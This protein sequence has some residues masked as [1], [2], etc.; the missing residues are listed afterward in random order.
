[1]FSHQNSEL[2][3]SKSIVKD[4]FD[5]LEDLAISSYQDQLKMEAKDLLSFEQF[6]EEYF[7]VDA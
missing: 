4:Y 2:Y 3:R 7:A 1:M 5:A 6:I